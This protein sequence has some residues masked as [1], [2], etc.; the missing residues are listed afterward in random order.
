MIAHYNFNNVNMNSSIAADCSGFGHHGTF[1]GT[2]ATTSAAP[3]GEHGLYTLEGH[4]DYVKIENVYLSAD[5]ISINC[6]FKSGAAGGKHV[7]VNIDNL[8]SLTIDQNGYIVADLVCEDLTHIT[9]A[10]SSSI[11]NDTWHMLTLVYINEVGVNIYLDSVLVAQRLNTD[12]KKLLKGLKTI[13]IGGGPNIT[14]DHKETYISDV[15]IFS[16]A[17]NINDI[18][19]YYKVSQSFLSNGCVLAYNFNSDISANFHFTQK[20]ELKARDF[21]ERS[22]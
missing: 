6:W 19:D 22:Q 18:Q 12:K 4:K 3:R 5:D 10:S 1:I 15:R 14:T 16:A 9:A 20:G 2:S 13:F 7:M 21:M 8:C 17:L 11:I